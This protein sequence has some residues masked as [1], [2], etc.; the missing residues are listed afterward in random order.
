[1]T[2][3]YTDQLK[4]VMDLF[5]NNEIEKCIVKAKKNLSDKT[6]PPY[7]VIKNCLLIACAS[8]TWEEADDWKTRA[9][10][11]Y[12]AFAEATR[13]VYE[14]SLMTLNDLRKELDDL[15]K[16]KK[17]EL[18]CEQIREAQIISEEDQEMI[19]REE[20]EGEEEMAAWAAFDSG[21]CWGLASDDYDELADAGNE[22][23]D[24]GDFDEL[25]KAENENE[26]NGFEGAE[27]VARAENANEIA[28]ARILPDR[29]MRR[30]VPTPD[31]TSTTTVPTIVVESPEA[32]TTS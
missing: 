15:D 8:D 10:Q 30:F 29:S 4:A 6:L 28:A 23:A 22:D 18:L 16:Q 27:E 26:D 12:T 9:E 21:A 5:D 25:A 31:T 32:P 20:R 3:V 24:L 17:E 19:D 7:Y 11:A 2:D 13:K 1:M 14:D